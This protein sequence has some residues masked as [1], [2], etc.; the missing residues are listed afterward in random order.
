M[1]SAAALAS[2]LGNRLTAPIDGRKTVTLRGTR[3]SR[4]HDLT[5]NG[6]VDDSVRVPLNIQFQRTADQ[7]ADL[8][9][10]VEEQ[11]DPA[12]PRYHAWLTPEEFGER[13]GLSAGDMAKVTAWLASQGFQIDA[14]ARSRTYVAFTAT[15]GQV[16]KTFKSDLRRFTA[17]GKTHFANTQDVE[18]PEA[19]A[20]LIATMRGL[21]DFRIERRSSVRP[22]AT[23]GGGG[24][25]VGPG[26]LA[27][28]YN[29]RPLW[30][31]GIDGSGQKIA[32]VGRSQVNLSDV[33]SFRSGFN[34][35]KNDP[36]L[37]PVPGLVVP[38]Y[39]DSFLEGELDIEWAGA[40]A[41]N[42]TI[43]YVYTAN[44]LDAVQYTVDHALAPVMSYSYSACERDY[45]T[46]SLAWWNNL[47]QQA[48][49]QGMT[50]VAASGDAGAA[51]CERQQR[52]SIG[53]GGVWA[54]V[55]ATLPQVTGV[56]G[57]EFSE[58]TGAYWSAANAAVSYI[59]EIAWNDSWGTG[60][61][62]S[63]GGGASVFY[64]KPAWQTGPG[65]PA[66]NARWVPD[67]SFTAS[68]DHDPYLV[69]ET[70]SYVN[71]G[72]TS[73]ATPFFAGVL[74]MLNQQLAINGQKPGLGNINP[75]LYQLA[76]TTTGVFHDIT[77]GSNVVP[78]KA[79]TAGCTSD[80]YGY[81]ATPGYDPVTGLGSLNVAN[82]VDNW[83]GKP[84]TPSTPGVANTSTSVTATP[85]ALAANGSTVVKATV[86]AATG[87]ALPTG[88][89]YFSLGDKNLGYV[90]LANSAGV[91]SASLTVTGTQLAIGANTIT[92]WY[93]GASDFLS[94]TGTVTVTVSAATS[95][96]PAVVV[97]SVTPSPVT[98]T[99]PDADGYNFFFTIRLAETAGTA[100]TLTG[101]VIDGADYSAQIAAFFGSANLP[102]N[103]AL[104]TSIR[105]KDMTL[106]ANL[107]YQFSGVDASG[108]KWSKQLTVPFAGDAPPPANSAVMTLTSVPQPIYR[109]LTTDPDCEPGLP[110]SQQVILRET[111][112]SEVR[113]TKFTAG[114]NDFTDNIL[115]WFGTMRLP[116][117]G[118]ISAHICWRINGLVGNLSYE[119]AGVDESGRTVSAKMQTGFL[120]NASSD[121][122]LNVSKSP[123]DLSADIS[124]SATGSVNVSVPAGEQWTVMSYVKNQKI[125]WL[126][127]TP[128][129]GKGPAQVNL[130]ASSSGLSP[131]VYI[132]NLVFQSNVTPQY[133]LVPVSFTIGAASDMSISSAGNAASFK[134]VFAPGMLT[135]LFGTHLSITTKAADAVPLP[136][137]LEGVTVMVNGIDAPLWY[138][139]PGQIN[140]QIP[141]EIPTGSAIVAVNNN[142]RV[143]STV[144]TVDDSAP[145]IFANNGV[146]VPAATAKR[147]SA[148][149]LYLTGD[150]EL[151]PMLDSGAPPAANTP[152]AQLP[153]P[154]APL[155]VTVGG[156]KADVAFAGNPWLVGVTQVNFTVPA[157][158]PTGAQPVVVTVGGIVSAPATITVL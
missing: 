90:N 29:L 19:L 55:P 25:G 126:T 96:K 100:A 89:V 56:G 17:D 49:A 107:V 5:D 135:T 125:N 158:A 136:K 9:R 130:T 79:G 116:A 112:G 40:S 139:S 92:A 101:F 134:Q 13:F 15:A 127:V 124:K 140:F 110:Y 12:S 153:K 48:N 4:I 142:G 31:R 76:Q 2:Q 62:A 148:A 51:G 108:Q 44:I 98:R 53:V 97:P 143:T 23:G 149:V 73:A 7:I 72:G 138:V 75:R 95:S 60:G 67:V 71:T 32:V 91:A 8:G 119:I 146:I 99:T 57:T 128:Q 104:T 35:S 70:G 77:A 21:D 94:S 83:T 10:L 66:Y 144:I 34:L 147:G 54:N 145:G 102:A 46:Q 27:T 80:R 86:K 87:S 81:N 3:N 41:P 155:T 133:L 103:G 74:A 156:V 59:P 151:T 106:P 64:Q 38:G 78:C 33:Q 114:G 137:R 1:I 14:V 122:T 157:N 117:Y 65:V 50:W 152:V 58:G 30:Q 84:S 16:R 82:F 22:M 141:Y 129:S 88:P 37:I 123:I 43:L 132:A 154:R 61:L 111:G 47:A 39:T 6:A 28:I 121:G 118:G 150:G 26:D 113:L 11:Q 42:A 63:T 18:V 52:D 45:T 85:A 93:G 36:Q 109:S 69:V 115:S 131:G 68:W 24:R 120:P 105:A 20:P